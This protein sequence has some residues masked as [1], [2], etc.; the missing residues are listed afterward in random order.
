MK[1]I[2]S[3]LLF[4]SFLLSSCAPAA[5]P[6]NGAA[7]T[8]AQVVD[9]LRGGHVT[10]VAQLHSGEV[11]LTLT[12]GAEVSAMSPYMDAIFD[13]VQACGAPCADI[14]LAME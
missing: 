3:L 2:I 11:R 10:M 7:I 8:W 13:E 9:L 5:L 14:V 6:A 4:L 12:N 1:P